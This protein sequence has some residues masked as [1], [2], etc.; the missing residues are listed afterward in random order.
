MAF[1]EL[2]LLLLGHVRAAGYRPVKPRVIA[3]QL[4][5]P[6]AQR[7]EVRKADQA[8]RQAGRDRLRQEPSRDAPGSRCWS[9]QVGG[10]RGHLPACAAGGFGF[11]RPRG[12]RDEG[13][14]GRDIYIPARTADASSGDL[15]RVRLRRPKTVGTE[16]RVRGEIV[17]VLQR[18]TH[19]FV[20]TYFE[21]QG[22]WPGPG[23]RQRLRA[24]DP[25]R[26]SRRQGRTPQRQG[27][28]RDGP[29]PVSTARRRGRDHRGLRT[30]RQAGCRHAVRSCGSSA[31]PRTSPT[32]SS[33]KRA[34]QAEAFD[35]RDT[36]TAVR[37]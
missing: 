8:A 32:T 1:T 31:C 29:L 3:R 35:A 28:H 36:S 25:R 12:V 17:E 23:R 18:E 19:Q 9:G 14:R 24:A 5:L 7:A 27:R 33:K 34:Q 20:G 37:T 30:A 21:P 2:E 26:R 10:R 16:Q 22:D 15:V 4:G 13:G 11:V 6:D